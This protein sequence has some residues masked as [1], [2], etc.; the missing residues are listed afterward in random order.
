MTVAQIVDATAIAV[1]ALALVAAVVYYGLLHRSLPST[2]LGLPLL[3][4]LVALLVCRLFSVDV[5][6]S[7]WRV[8]VWVGYLAVFFLALALPRRWVEWVALVLGWALALACVAEA[9]LTWGRPRLLGNPNITAAWLLATIFLVPPSWPW[10]VAGAAGILAT[11]SRGALVALMTV[12]MMELPRLLRWIIP[13]MMVLVALA[14]VFGRS[15]TVEKRL[16]TWAEAFRLFLERPLVGWGPGCYPVVA[17]Y[18][19]GKDHADNFLLTVAAET[20][21]VGLAAWAWLLM[22]AGQA[23]IR[24]E[25][26]ARLGLVA[27]G[28]HQLVDDTFWWYWPGVCLMVCLAWCVKR[29]EI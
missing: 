17:R 18:E 5:R 12:G 13:G 26:R 25:E 1:L 22:A 8:F 28:I 23:V 4:V 27:W 20:G 29:G 19:E 21:L 3:A 10:S 2:P 9:V 24:S 16:H 6:Y 15:S 7:S 14:L 11:G